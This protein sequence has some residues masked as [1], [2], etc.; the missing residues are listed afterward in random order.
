MS[1]C[2]GPERGRLGERLR[3]GLAGLREL[4][5]LWAVQRG[6]VQGALGQLDGPR[7]LPLGKLHW[8]R[9]EDPLGDPAKLEPPPPGG[10]ETVAPG[11][12]TVVDTDSRPSSGFYEMGSLSDSCPSVRS[13]GP[14]SPSRSRPC[15]ADEA[16]VHLLH[17]RCLAGTP[18]PVSTGDLE[19][20]WSLGDAC[21][22]QPPYERDLVSRSTSE[23]Y[24]YPSPLHAVA[25]QSPLFTGP[26]RRERPAPLP[27]TLP[28]SAPRCTP[29]L[30]AEQCRA[31][32]DRYISALVLRYKCRAASSCPEPGHLVGQQKSRSLSSVCSS[33]LGAGPPAGW[34]IRR[35]ISTCSHLR[36]VEYAEGARDTAGL[37]IPGGHSSAASS[38]GSIQSGELMV[39]LL[40]PLLLEGPARVLGLPAPPWG[41]D[42]TDRE[43]LYHG[44]HVSRELVKA[45]EGAEKSWLGP[46]GL[47]RRITLCRQPGEQGTCCSLGVNVCAVAPG[48]QAPGRHK[49]L[50][51]LEISGRREGTEPCP[52]P[53]GHH[54]AFSMDS[55]FPGEADAGCRLLGRA[56]PPRGAATPG[57][58]IS[59]L[60]RARSFKELKRMVS[61]PFRPL[62]SKH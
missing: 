14:G 45:S 12:T 32:L 22:Q 11:T 17:L 28:A 15:S 40:E 42:G 48:P 29:A 61:R 6:A 56:L 49:W 31:R 27:A 46:W 54:L 30:S 53:L 37:E 1:W 43:R 33:P 3:A 62:K 20:I 16:A 58:G 25:L 24:R 23:I 9:S 2:G 47:L 8:S 41:G 60:R 39:E 5:L 52:A 35:R 19:S 57:P 50:S 4:E 55:C 7:E 21:P 59:R 18:R 38:M 44:K 26:P 10:M 34:K 51:V 36:S 13:E